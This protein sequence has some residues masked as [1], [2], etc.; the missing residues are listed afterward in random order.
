MFPRT[1]QLVSA[2][3]ALQN[4]TDGVCD[5]VW[6]AALHVRVKMRRI[7]CQDDHAASGVHSHNLH[8][9]RI[10]AHMMDAKPR[11][12]LIVAVMKYNTARKQSANH[13]SNI[14]RIE[15]PAHERVRHMSA[16][17]ELNLAV[18]HVVSRGREQV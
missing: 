5:W 1:R 6:N 3:I 15:R 9:H 18:L 17:A 8:S 12:D 7:G 10:A 14:F 11:R 13:R 16:C 2:T 4:F